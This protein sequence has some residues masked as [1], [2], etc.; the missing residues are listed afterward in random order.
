MSEEWDE[1]VHEVRLMVE[2]LDAFRDDLKAASG[3]GALTL[4]QVLAVE[5]MIGQALGA[6]MLLDVYVNSCE[7][8]G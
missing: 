1:V 5:V 7:S 6:G 8:Q 2:R 3:S 4:P